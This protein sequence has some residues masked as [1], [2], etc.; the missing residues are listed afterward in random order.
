MMRCRASGYLLPG[1]PTLLIK[2]TAARKV[3]CR[4]CKYRVRFMSS[5]DQLNTS[6]QFN[7]PHMTHRST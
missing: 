7:A 4:E 5:A 3:P 1:T 2:G 6:A